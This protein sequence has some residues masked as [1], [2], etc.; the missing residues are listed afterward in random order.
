MATKTAKDRIL[1][2][3]VRC[4]S[5]GV[6]TWQLIDETRCSAAARRVWDWQQEGHRIRKVKEGVG[7]YRWVY[8]GAPVTRPKQMTFSD[9]RGLLRVE[10][11]T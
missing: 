3:L 10:R 11:H 7:I 6:T 9:L 5:R 8:E 4:G 1:D 2:I